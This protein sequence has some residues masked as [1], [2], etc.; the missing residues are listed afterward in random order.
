MDKNLI[1]SPGIVVMLLNSPLLAEQV[2]EA[3]ELGI[4]HFL[5]KPLDAAELAKI[6]SP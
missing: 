2:L 6:V 4:K 3:N 1:S 5:D